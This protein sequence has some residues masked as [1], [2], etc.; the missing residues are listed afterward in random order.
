MKLSLFK[1]W[2][3]AWPV[4]NWK[5]LYGWCLTCEDSFQP[6]PSSLSHSKLLKKNAPSWR[7]EEQQKAFHKVKEVLSSSLTMI[8]YVRRFP[9]TLYL[10]FI[11]ESMDALLAQE[12]EGI[13]HPVYNLSKSLWS[14]E[15]SSSLIES[16]CLVLC[17]YLLAHYLNMVMKSNPPKYLY[18]DQLCQTY[19]LITFVAKWVWYYYYCS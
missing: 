7:D 15:T 11:N 8:S 14:D 16:H 12:A 19:C 10:T 17:H 18:L 3:P 13:E 1:I 9:L 4:S 5:V 6:W 2:S